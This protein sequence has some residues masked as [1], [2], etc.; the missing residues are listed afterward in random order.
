MMANL[1]PIGR[2]SQVTRLSIKALRLYAEDGLLHPAHI[3]PDSGYRY[4][5]LG[6]AEVAA[7][8]RFLRELDMPLEEIRTILRA[9]NPA[10]L[11]TLLLQYQECIQQRIAQYQHS[12]ILLERLLENKEEIMSYTVK[13]KEVI[14]QPIMS[15]R[16]QTS[17]DAF[18]QA[19]PSAMHELMS[20]AAQ[21]NLWQQDIHPVVIHHAYSEEEAD[22]EVGLPV[23]KPVA[24]EGSIKSNTIQ[25]GRVA[26][27][28][29]IG[30]YEE[31]GMVYPALATW[32]HDHGY[33][34]A[35]PSREVF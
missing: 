31:L 26:S 20:Y 35:G 10:E 33:E 32:I 8:I 27:I 16:L 30:P 2:F 19:I 12:L 6:Q 17:P 25:G 14:P 7:R 28:V 18:D 5:S 9:E 29:H 3:D 23:E 11:R 34:M 24:G 22:I 4:Y 21:L 1:L 13:V 15:I